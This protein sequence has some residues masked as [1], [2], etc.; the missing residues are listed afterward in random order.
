MELGKKK[1][2]SL[3]KMPVIESKVRK[4]KDGSYIINQTTI[5]SIKPVEYYQAVLDSEAP[6][7]GTQDE[8]EILADAEKLEA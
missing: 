8:E 7:P 6:S 2:E 3:R 5:T 4:S 1:L